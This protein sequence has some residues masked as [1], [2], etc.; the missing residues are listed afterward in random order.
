MNCNKGDAMIIYLLDIDKKM[1]EEWNQQFNGKKD[2][3]VV[4][5]DFE[6]FMNHHQGIEAVVSPGNSFGIMDGGLDQAIVDYFGIDVQNATQKYIKK[7]YLGEQPVGTSFSISIPGDKDCHLIHTPTMRIP[8]VI[9][10]PRI[11]YTCM[12]ST[13][14]E[15][16]KSNYKEVVIPAF[17]HCTG[18]V[19]SPVVAYLMRKGYESVVEKDLCENI[20]WEKVDRSIDNIFTNYYR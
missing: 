5:D 15:M 18:A 1:T 7:A 13:L 11:I 20:S 3:I 19:P 17:G 9:L 2:V 16:K 10:D 4:N 6:C 14:V 12:R 8:Q